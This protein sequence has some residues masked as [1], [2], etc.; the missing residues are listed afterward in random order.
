MYI[1]LKQF[2]EKHE[3]PSL[4][5]LRSI[6]FDATKDKN[7]FLPAFSKVGRRVLVSPDKFFKLVE[8]SGKNPKEKK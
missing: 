7:P 1:T 2:A 5:A 6:Y 8:K 3:W 4:S